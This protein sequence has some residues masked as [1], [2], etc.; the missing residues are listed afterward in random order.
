M[1]K[2][3]QVNAFTTNVLKGNPAGVVLNSESLS[4]YEMQMIA[5]DL[6]LSETAFIF[7]PVNKFANIKI[8]WFSPTMELPLWG[9]STIASI[10]VLL[11]E[12]IFNLVEG[13][14]TKFVIEYNGGVLPVSVSRLNS[15]DYEIWFT[16]PVP[17]FSPFGGDQ[18]DIFRFLG[19]HDNDLDS[20]LPIYQSDSKYLFVPVLGL[21]T[22]RKLEPNFDGLKEIMKEEN[23]NGICTFSRE[24]IRTTSSFHS[25]FFSPVFGINEDPVTGTANAQLA[26]YWLNHVLPSIS[27][28]SYEMIGE[29]GFS[30]DRDGEVKVSMKVYKNQVVALEIG[31]T[32]RIFLS[33]YLNV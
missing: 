14:F 22:L 2:Y 8:R 3:Y 17:K 33:G 13:F 24:T 4:D 25:R 16:V 29:Q 9:H 20:R 5:R 26:V 32:G 15:E 19:M 28:E 21:L 30:I 11:K 18:Q 1:R 6:N 10:Y 27:K 12:K 7:P 23:L 31:G